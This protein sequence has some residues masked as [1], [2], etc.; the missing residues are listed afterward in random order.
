MSPPPV[1]GEGGGADGDEEVIDACAGGEKRK[2]FSPIQQG[3][4]L[5]V[6]KRGRPQMA[7][8]LD[9]DFTAE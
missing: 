9:K 8:K 5:P 1:T 7:K 3:T 2:V 6:S 4:G